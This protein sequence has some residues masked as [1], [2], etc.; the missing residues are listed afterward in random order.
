MHK[1]GTFLM[2]VALPLA[3]LAMALCI[4]GC[5]RPQQPN[6]GPCSRPKV[7][8]F[9]AAWCIPCQR[10]KPVLAQLQA[11]GV[12]VEIIDL[13]ARPDLAA[14]YGVT[15]VPTFFVYICGKSTVRTQDVT[16]VVRC[17]PWMQ[18]RG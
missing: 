2:R 14:K 1:A 8:A 18:S 9:T 4:A 16:V 6:S 17:F 13:D 3:A 7:L 12:E 5:E 15:S 10:A 11:F